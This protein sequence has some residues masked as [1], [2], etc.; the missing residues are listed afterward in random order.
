MPNIKEQFQ[1]HSVV[2]PG[3]AVTNIFNLNDKKE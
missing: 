1:E 3:P 2:T